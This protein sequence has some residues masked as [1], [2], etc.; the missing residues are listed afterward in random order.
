MVRIYNIKAIKKNTIAMIKAITNINNWWSNG[1]SK[2]P[3]EKIKIP[4][5]TQKL[6]HVII[7]FPN[8]FLPCPD[9]GSSASIHTNKGKITGAKKILK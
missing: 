3:F 2:T 8:A 6:I 4:L 1:L 5:P 9:V 7:W